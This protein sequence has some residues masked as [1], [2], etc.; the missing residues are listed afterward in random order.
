MNWLAFIGN[1]C[2]YLVHDGYRDIDDDLLQ[3]MFGRLWDFYFPDAQRPLLPIVELKK[4]Q[5]LKRPWIQMFLELPSADRNRLR[6]KAF[7]KDEI[8]VDFAWFSPKISHRLQIMHLEPI[9]AKTVYAAAALAFS[10]EQAYER[11]GKQVV[12][13]TQ[14]WHELHQRTNKMRSLKPPWYD[15]VSVAFFEMAKAELHFVDQFLEAT[16]P[17]KD[18]DGDGGQ[19]AAAGRMPS[20]NAPGQ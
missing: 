9:V 18:D 12:Y 11:N 7:T 5:I 10:K 4:L 6:D 13:C 14:L 19:A 16:K 1:D 15:D 8:R 3:F 2:T 17:K 20:G